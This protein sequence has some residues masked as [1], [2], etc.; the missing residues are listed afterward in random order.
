MYI[1]FVPVFQCS[2]YCC[3]NL[4][5]I[6]SWGMSKCSGLVFFFLKFQFFLS[7]SKRKAG[8]T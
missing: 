2:V 6:N 4:K 1:V 8:H 5:D 3:V 7:D